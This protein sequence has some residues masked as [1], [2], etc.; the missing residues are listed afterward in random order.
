MQAPAEQDLFRQEYTPVTDENK[1]IILEV[2]KK[3]QELYEMMYPHTN[4]YTSMA[5]TD[6]EKS[7]AM[8]AKGMTS[9]DQN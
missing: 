8:F 6:L 9:F 2:K 7:I 5:I 1:A 3:A 4:R